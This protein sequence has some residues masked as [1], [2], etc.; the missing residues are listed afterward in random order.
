M[1]VAIITGASRGLGRA[2]AHGLAAGGWSLVLDARGAD[3]L[4]ATG[5]ELAPTTRI[6]AIPGS[7]T[8]ASHRDALVEAAER[9]GGVNLL[10]NN[11]SGLGPSP[12]PPLARYPLDVLRELYE[13]NVLAPLALVQRALP[14][15]RAHRGTI[16]N[17]TSDAAVESYAGWGGYGSNKAALEQL[18]N[19]LGAE[20]PDVRVYTFDPGDMRTQMHQDAFP[21]D[22]ISDRPE[23]ETVV[24]ALLRLLRDAPASGRFRVSEFAGATS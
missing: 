1:P 10:V 18:G 2:L 12:Q 11:A 22:D 21:G 6:V 16:V 7:V 3:A 23:P 15:L 24:P 17:I 5:A 9:F 8:D 14:S 4:S 20:E 13:T 19:V